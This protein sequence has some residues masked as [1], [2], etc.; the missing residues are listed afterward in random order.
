MMM[1]MMMTLMMPICTL[2]NISNLYADDDAR[3]MTP[4]RNTRSY[5]LRSVPSSPGRSFF[6][7]SSSYSG[8]SLRALRPSCFGSSQKLNWNHNNF[9]P[10]RHHHHHHH[11]LQ[12]H[13]HHPLRHL[14][15]HQHHLHHHHH[16]LNLPQGPWCS[17]PLARVTVHQGCRC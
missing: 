8:E 5:T 12:N 17:F 11:Q 6:S 16:D 9:H 3:S 10:L 13:H 14:H 15:H 4:S 1:M 7:S 2:L